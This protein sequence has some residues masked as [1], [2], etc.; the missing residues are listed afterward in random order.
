MRPTNTIAGTHMDSSNSSSR[1][2]K[3]TSSRRSRK[4]TKRR[5]DSS[6]ESSARR[7]RT[8]TAK[9]SA[10]L[11]VGFE[12]DEN[13][14]VKTHVR[15]IRRSQDILA[16]RDEDAVNKLWWSKEELDEILEREQN[17]FE[18][19]SKC[20]ST[21]VDNVLKLWE[22]CEAA[23]Q[24][25]GGRPSRTEME[26]IA[27]APARGM[28]NDVVVSYVAG[29]RQKAIQSVIKTQRSMAREEDDVRTTTMRRRYRHHSRAALEFAKNLA[30]GD[31]RVA[32][33]ILSQ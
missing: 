16:K 17:V 18:V 32:A 12:V 3:S 4:T 22:Q 23:K 33:A 15:R 13:D 11:R 19:F 24:T 28:E 6:P 5:L 14:C 27:N 9:R 21:Y 20:C 31:A 8:H 2:E 10:K 25:E 7:S 26:K 30:N 29:S 1:S